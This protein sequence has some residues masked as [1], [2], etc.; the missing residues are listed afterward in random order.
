MT[1]RKTDTADPDGTTPASAP[2]AR[3]RGPRKQAP[4]LSKVRRVSV[5]DELVEQMTRKIVSGAW[6]PGSAVPS[7]RKFAASTGTSMLTVREAIRALQVRGWVETRH[8]VG[9]FVVDADRREGY[10]PWQ[11]GAS[12]VEE[13][14][15]LI[16][17]REAIESAII[18]LAT[19]RRTDE[20]L[21][22]LS[23]IVDKM[24]TARDT[25][26][27]LE[28][29]GE[30]HIALAE[31]AHNRILLRSMLAIRSPMQR[32]MAN[33]LLLDLERSGN[34]D[35]S[36]ADHRAIV[37]SIRSGNATVGADA[38]R[39]ITDRGRTHMDTLRAES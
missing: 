14:M 29:D 7:L 10:S 28:A 21:R 4:E 32:L 22:A 8:G 23:A 35:R 39:H 26:A 37:E 25:T 13:Y 34:L 6:P 2:R 17:A 31:A 5:V 24:A 9:T 11:L 1:V 15:E 38:L 12:D 16:E 30:F 20:D 18:Q 27:F 3:G 19:T 33:Q 36:V